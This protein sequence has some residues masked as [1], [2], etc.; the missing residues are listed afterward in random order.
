[1]MGVVNADYAL[2][3]C[4]EYTIRMNFTTV[5]RTW[6]PVNRWRHDVPIHYKACAPCLGTTEYP[7]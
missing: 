1:M 4:A 3:T 2:T 7:K 5:P 6:I